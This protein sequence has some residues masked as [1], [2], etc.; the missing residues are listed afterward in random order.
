MLR[1]LLCIPHCLPYPC[2]WKNTQGKQ[3]V[4]WSYGARGRTWTGTVF[5]P[6]DFKSVASTNFA[7]RAYWRGLFKTLFA[8][9][10]TAKSALVTHLFATRII[11]D[12]KR[13][14]E[15]ISLIYLA[16]PTNTIHLSKLL[17]LEARVGIE[18]TMAELQSTA[19]PLCYRALMS[20]LV[21]QTWR[22]R[23]SRQ[24]QQ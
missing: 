1:V 11:H 19:L 23:Y 8:S 2:N 10:R 5:P 24:Y 3:W 21:S 9:L 18:P 17:N 16:W 20:S 14:W 13:N 4:T 7:T 6:T 15:W 22:G 12:Q